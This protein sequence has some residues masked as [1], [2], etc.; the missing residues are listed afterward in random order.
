MIQRWKNFII[1]KPIFVLRKPVFW[2]VS[3]CGWVTASL[4]FEG[5]YRLNLQLWIRTGSALLRTAANG[6]ITRRNNPEHQLH[7]QSRR[8]NLKLPFSY[9]YEHIS[10]YLIFHICV[11]LMQNWFSITEWQ[12]KSFHSIW[13]SISMNIKKQHRKNVKKREYCSEVNVSIQNSK[14]IAVFRA[15][16][17]YWNIYYFRQQ[18]SGI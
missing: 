5:T 3:L 1:C 2:V 7:Q 10:H 9:C 14:D 16:Y 18:K 15:L 11:L 4:N 17:S 6:E 13:T 12:D 8:G